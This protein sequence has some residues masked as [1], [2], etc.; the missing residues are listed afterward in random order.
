M[1]F[2]SLSRSLLGQIFKFF[3][4]AFTLCA[5]IVF[6]QEKRKVEQVNGEW[7]IS[8]D[9]TPIQA[10]ENAIN[11]AKVEALRQAG[12]PE[13]ISESNVLYHSESPQRMKELFESLTTTAI[14][15]ELAEVIVTKEE[16]KINEQ[17][18]IMYRVWIDATVVIHN[19]PK[20]PIFGA[21][22]KGLHENY[23]SPDKLT[24]EIQPWKDGYLT[25]FILSDKE[26]VQLFPNKLERQ[27]KLLALK[28]YEFPISRGLDYEVT[29]ESAMEVNYVLMLYT[30]EEI[31]FLKEQNPQNIL[32]FVS[33][34][35]PARKWLKTYSILI[36]K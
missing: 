30:K 22:V 25:V 9:I 5:S 20:D 32:T 34:I 26:G 13:I 19:N 33:T 12:V 4:R 29:A 2:K 31:P 35:D 18:N 8:N 17:G 24:F 14:S 3:T 10:R 28:K 15:G 1:I 21:D 23:N 7:E 16:K 11:Q 6:A 27:E 36:K